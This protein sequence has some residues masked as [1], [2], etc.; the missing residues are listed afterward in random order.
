MKKIIKL[1]AII[2]ILTNSSLFAQ[3]S[4]GRKFWVGFIEPHIETSIC[5]RS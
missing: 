4:E 5:I 2:C 1:T 3:S